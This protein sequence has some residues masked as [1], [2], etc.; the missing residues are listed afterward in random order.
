M[1][2]RSA[3]HGLGRKRVVDAVQRFVLGIHAVLLV[4][5]LAMLG[6]RGESEPHVATTPDDLKIEALT[7]SLV[8]GDENQSLSIGSDGAATFSRFVPSD[9]GAPPLEERSFT[10]DAQRLAG[11]WTLIQQHGFFELE[12]LYSRADVA[13]GGLASITVTANGVSHTVQCENVPLPP[14]E[15]VLA[16]L[17]RLAPDGASLIYKPPPE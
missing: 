5:S 15:A 6:C 17:N 9:I 7:G 3:S 8:P 14:I 11:L 4:A 13:D 16:E 1:S 2:S 10:V 12:P